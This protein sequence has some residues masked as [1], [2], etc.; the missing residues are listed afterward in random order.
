M[1][2]SLKILKAKGKGASDASLEPARDFHRKAQ[3]RVDFV[4]AEN[5]MGFHAPGESLRIL[6]EAID[7][8]TGTVSYSKKM[9]NRNE[10]FLSHFYFLS[11]LLLPR[12]MPNQVKKLKVESLKL[13]YSLDPKEEVK[14]TESGKQ[15]LDSKTI[16]L[17][18]SKKFLLL[19]RSG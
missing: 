11:H 13:K 8:R 12:R 15:P 10:I 1:F 2:H 5:S 9:V 17:N 14:S 6:A 7:F 16:Y 4:A 3:W 19:Q 18:L